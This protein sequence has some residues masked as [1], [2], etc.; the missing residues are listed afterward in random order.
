MSVTHQPWTHPAD[1]T[2][3][4]ASAQRRAPVPWRVATALSFGIAAV[5][6]YLV[7][8][9]TAAGQQWDQQVLR[10][11]RAD[12]SVLTVP[13]WARIPWISNPALWLAVAAVV[14][15]FGLLRGLRWRTLAYLAFAP[16][17]ILLARLLR[18]TVLT[19][20][21]IPGGWDAANAAPSG[22]ATAAAAT[23]VVLTMT[24]PRL[25]RP[26][27]AVISAAWVTLIG[28][29]LVVAGWH[30]PGDV[31]LAI[32]LVGALTA[33]LL[34][35]QGSGDPRRARRHVAGR[36]L[37]LAAVGAAAG[38][39]AIWATVGGAG[40]GTKT[41]QA[42]V[43]IAVCAAVTNAVCV[44]TSGRD[45]AQLSAGRVPGRSRLGLRA[46]TGRAR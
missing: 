10:Y 5:A 35:A 32:L 9:G 18:L 6:T 15:T 13:P 45:S 20:P 37:V 3:L 36:V 16:A 28:S 33:A 24:A 40:L 4:V 8:A 30:R 44:S 22:H 26:I 23:A 46:G 17:A 1:G 42:F 27:I 2:T 39:A 11:A 21:S 43:M 12:L 38:V 34:A 29:Q 19:R 7:T 31:L 41:T 25:L 14:T